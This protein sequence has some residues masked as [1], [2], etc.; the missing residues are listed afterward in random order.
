MSDATKPR[1]S[2]RAGTGLTTD[3]TSWAGALNDSVE[4]F[5]ARVGFGKPNLL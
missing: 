3:G 5:A 4:N 2:V 1:V